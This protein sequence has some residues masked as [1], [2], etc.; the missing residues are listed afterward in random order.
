[1]RIFL[2]LIYSFF[3]LLCDDHF[4]Y[5]YLNG[6]Y[7]WHSISEL[8]LSRLV[9]ARIHA[10]QAAQATAYNTETQQGLLADTPLVAFCLKLIYGKGQ[11]SY[12]INN[13]NICRNACHVL[14]GRSP[15]LKWV[16]ESGAHNRDIYY[17][18]YKQQ[19]AKGYCEIICC[20]KLSC[21][22]PGSLL[23]LTKS[24]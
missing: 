9:V 15:Y 18:A 2:C 1:M 7:N 6:Q 10:Y 22:V 24:S 13:A 16:V 14:W 11:K 19:Y 21:N 17:G 23:V 8:R 20:A 5:Q 4:Q 3:L 12:N